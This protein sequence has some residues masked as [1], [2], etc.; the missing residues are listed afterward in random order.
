MLPFLSYGQL[1]L[2]VILVKW[3]MLRV[4]ELNTTILFIFT[5]LMCEL[6]CQIVNIR[7]NSS[8]RV[9]VK[10]QGTKNNFVF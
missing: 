7:C 2:G 3:Y 5:G 9:H 1:I 6:L 10:G 4:K 8:Q